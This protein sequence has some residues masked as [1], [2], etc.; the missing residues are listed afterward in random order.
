MALISLGVAVIQAEELKFVTVLSQPIGAFAQVESLNEERAS[1]TLFVNFCNTSV[2]TG[3]IDVQGMVKMNELRLTGSDARAGSATN[4][5]NYQITEADGLEVGSG[6]SLLG[7]RLLANSANPQDITVA[8]S[9][10]IN[11][12]STFIAA[13]IPSMTIGGSTHIVYP[14]QSLVGSDV[15]WRGSTDDYR[16]NFKVDE[17]KGVI[18]D[19]TTE[20]TSYPIRTDKRGGECR[21]GNSVSPFSS[22]H[23][24][25]EW[26][27]QTCSSQESPSE[28]RVGTIFWRFNYDTC[29]W[30]EADPKGYENTSNWEKW[31][32]WTS[33]PSH[34]NC[35]CEGYSSGSYND[36]TA[37]TFD[38]QY[39]NPRFK[40]GAI[41]GNMVNES[42]STRTRSCRY[43]KVR[44]FGSKYDG[45]I[46]ERYDFNGCQWTLTSENCY[47]STT[48]ADAPSSGRTSGYE[49]KKRS[50]STDSK[51]GSKYDGTITARYYYGKGNCYWDQYYDEDC[52]CSSRAGAPKKQ[53]SGT[54]TKTRYCSSENSKWTGTITDTYNYD[55]CSWSYGDNSSCKC[56][57]QPSNLTKTESCPAGYT[58]SKTYKYNT[59]LDKCAWELTSD[60][61]KISLHWTERGSRETGICTSGSLGSYPGTCPSASC[62]G[63]CST[64]GA[65]CFWESC[66][67]VG[68]NVIRHECVCKS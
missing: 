65:T 4:K 2:S 64:E 50:C 56:A 9:T 63:T 43:D 1:K 62:S 34:H 13:D 23:C 18:K 41:N 46:N 7:G 12:G 39:G 5:L 61:C 33:I 36:S 22:R 35:Q 55:T 68:A 27:T 40:S 25:N 44:G 30:Y 31:V 60:T 19:G 58:G 66:A 10:N 52:Y 37:T 42:S 29:K 26:N 20:F 14:A 15:H 11:A 16:Y 28:R 54:S 57:N 51:W 53:Y 21:C 8:A 67:S 32:K 45:N 17:N 47:C 49:D 38:Q 59:S 3:K 24:T 48:R 6:G